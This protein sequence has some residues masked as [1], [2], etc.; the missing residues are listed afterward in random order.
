[1]TTQP[2]NP[3]APAAAQTKDPVAV[4]APLREWGALLLVLAT[5][6]FLLYAL[7]DLVFA[8]GEA[9][10]FGVT[11]GFSL[12]ADSHYGDFVGLVPIAFPLIAVLLAT[13]VKPVGPRAKL[14]T[15]LALVDYAV[16]GLLG[17]ITLF[18]AFFHQMTSDGQ[19]VSGLLTLVERLTWLVVFAFAGFVV[20]RIYLGAF[21]VPRPKPAPGVYGYPA[22]YQQG[23]PAGYP[24]Q[25]AY[26]AYQATTYPSGGYPAV[27]QP[28]V[29]PV[30]P[31]S[32]PPSTPY[33]SYPTPSSPQ[34]SYPTSVQPAW[35]APGDTPSPPAPPTAA[36][37][38]A[39]TG[40]AAQPGYA[41]QTGYQPYPTPPA[42]AGPGYVAQPGAPAYQ[43]PAPTTP[44]PP[45]PPIATPPPYDVATQQAGQPPSVQ[46][47]S[48]P[49]AYDPPAYDVATQKAAPAA[50]PATQANPEPATE[51]NPEPATQANPEP[52][53]APNATEDGSDRTQVLP[54]PPRPQ[55]ASPGDEPTQRWG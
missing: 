33:P 45:A 13:H 41:A 7:I 39:Q 12:R 34:P 36:A 48:T 25:P 52:A 24:Q 19:A 11:V 38:A 15:L 47:T 54:S 27:P 16:A 51:A 35:T 4:T 44:A 17:L 8:P 43:S 21:V 49:P 28:P 2:P 40:Y 50:E 18:V 30:Q 42:P 10:R 46:P 9:A 6:L 26:Q 29:Q 1:V 20:L 32:V 5:G 53:T 22:A 31:T 55:S 3:S 37:Y 23:Y 14:V